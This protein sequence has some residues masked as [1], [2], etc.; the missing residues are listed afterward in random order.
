LSNEPLSKDDFIKW[1]KE[2]R[3]CEKADKN[4]ICPY[5][6]KID[7]MEAK[8]GAV[9]KAVEGLKINISWLKRGYW[10]QAVCGIG[11]F[12]TVLMLALRFMGLL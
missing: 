2:L 3:E 8:I 12:L 9:E 7:S 6:G 4:P 1:L 5:L 10:I 11:S